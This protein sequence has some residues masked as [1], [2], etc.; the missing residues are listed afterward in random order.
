MKRK[1]TPSSS[2][3]EIPG[4]DGRALRFL[5]DDPSLRTIIG[6]YHWHWLHHGGTRRG[7]RYAPPSIGRR[8]YDKIRCGLLSMGYPDLDDD[9]FRCRNSC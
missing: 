2:T 6:L 3:F 1:P 9:M 4:L 5:A 7:F 8:T